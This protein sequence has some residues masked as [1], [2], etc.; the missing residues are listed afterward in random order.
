MTLILKV[1]FY[2]KYNIEHIHIQLGISKINR[3]E[4][5]FFNI[6]LD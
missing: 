6:T 5:S 1:V 2:P 4:V 3:I